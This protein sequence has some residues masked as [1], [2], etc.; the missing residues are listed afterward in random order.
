MLLEEQNQTTAINVTGNSTREFI[1]M[2]L[3][4]VAVIPRND[5][6]T[7]IFRRR[8]FSS[9][10]SMQLLCQKGMVGN[11]TPRT[12]AT[13]AGNGASSSTRSTFFIDRASTRRDFDP[14]H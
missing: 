4:F 6:P 7:K 5:L 9:R 12:R 14:S 2:S 8:S 10:L 13:P 3:G 11:A 1:I